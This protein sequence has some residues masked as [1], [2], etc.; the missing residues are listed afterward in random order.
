[1]VSSKPWT[2]GSDLSDLSGDRRLE[3]FAVEQVADAAE[4]VV[5]LHVNRIRAQAADVRLAQRPRVLSTSCTASTSWGASKSLVKNRSAPACA[6]QY[7]SLAASSEVSRRIGMSA[8]RQSSFSSR[9]AT[10]PET[11]GI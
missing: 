11:R 6:P 9:A 10:Y 7:R 8:V 4:H 2:L 1:M 5:V 3:Q